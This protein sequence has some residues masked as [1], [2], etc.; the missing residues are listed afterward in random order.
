[1]IFASFA[2][3]CVKLSCRYKKTLV[4]VGFARHSIF[5]LGCKLN[6]QDKQEKVLPI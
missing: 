5:Y 3:L 1:M 6:D 4:N 2:T